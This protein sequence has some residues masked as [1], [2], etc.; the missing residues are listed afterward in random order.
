MR[1]GGSGAK[2]DIELLPKAA[3]PVRRGD[4]LGTLTVSIGGETVAEAPIVAA[5][6][7]ERIGFFGTF[8]LLGLSLFGL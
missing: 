4:R 6:D 7:V 5:G 8:A 1:R 3:A 2:Y